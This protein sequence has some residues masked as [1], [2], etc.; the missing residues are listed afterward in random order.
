MSATTDI[1]QAMRNSGFV[2]ELAGDRLKVRV[3]PGC[4]S[5]YKYLLRNRKSEFIAALKEQQ[6][7]FAQPTELSDTER[8]LLIAMGLHWQYSAD[9]WA[10][11]WSDCRDHEQR[12]NWLRIAESEQPPAPKQGDT[13]L[14]VTIRIE[15]N[16]GTGRMQFD[17]GV[18]L[19]RWNE[20][21]FS[22]QIAAMPGATWWQLDQPKRC[23]DC[24][25]AQPTQ[26]TALVTCGAGREDYPACGAFWDSDPKPCNQWAPSANTHG[27]TADNEL[28][29]AR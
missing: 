27:Q 8:G 23:A 7:E 14:A 13:E 24:R 10:Q 20:Q 4:P 6:A 9:D 5:F 11:L 12:A 15:G 1:I 29:N 22:E 19:D 21:K 26:H 2:L 18:P 17:M 3:P 25:H 16:F 28:R